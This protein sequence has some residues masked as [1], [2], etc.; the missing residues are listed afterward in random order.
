MT[1]SLLGPSNHS[2]KE[3]LKGK[4]TKLVRTVRNEVTFSY[5]YSLLS[6][7]VSGKKY[8]KGQQNMIYNLIFLDK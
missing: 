1:F 2:E 6:K 8:D 3:G 5:A 4:K 7:D